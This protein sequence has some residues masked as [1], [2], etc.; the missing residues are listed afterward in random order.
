MYKCSTLLGFVLEL[1][2]SS[3]LCRLLRVYF[4][5]VILCSFIQNVK[6]PRNL[7]ST[8]THKHLESQELSSR[9]RIKKYLRLRHRQTRAALERLLFEFCKPEVIYR[10]VRIKSRSCAWWATV[11]ELSFKDTDWLQIVRLRKRDF[12]FICNKLSC[13]LK[14]EDTSLR[15]A[16]PIQKRVGVAISRLAINS[17]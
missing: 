10:S 3:L 5:R 9:R 6:V 14:K 2:S 15:R 13:S 12:D 4:R 16:I 1:S 8:S 7:V 11:V 17:D